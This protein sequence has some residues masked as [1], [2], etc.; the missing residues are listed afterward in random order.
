M[1][2]SSMG[3]LVEKS[4]SEQLSSYGITHEPSIDGRRYIRCAL[5]SL[6]LMSAD[7][8][9]NLLDLLGSV[10]GGPPRCK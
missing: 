4:I 9:V 2:C 7:E 8:A 1:K 10:P 6:G 3:E 5:G